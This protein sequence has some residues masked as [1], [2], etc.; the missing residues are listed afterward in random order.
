M[1]N[2]SKR[3]SKEKR[4][5]SLTKMIRHLVLFV[6]LTIFGVSTFLNW[7]FMNA[8]GL[9]LYTMNADTL[10]AS[11]SALMSTT[12]GLEAYKEA[13]METYRSVPEEIRSDPGSDAYKAYFAG[14]THSNFYNQFLNR[15]ESLSRNTRMQDLFLA[16]PDRETSSMVYLADYYEND[17]YPQQ[18]PGYYVDLND[19]ELAA[20]NEEN[21]KEVFF[22]RNRA[23]SL[24]YN[25]QCLAINADSGQTICYAVVA[26]PHIIVTISSTLFFVIYVI[27]CV[28]VFFFVMIFARRRMK[29]RLITPVSDISAAA[30]RYVQEKKG[31]AGKP[32]DCFSKLDI[33]T[34]DELEELSSI[35]TEMEQDIAVYE[36]DLARAA[37]EKGQIHAEMSLATSIQTKMLPDPHTVFPDR[38]DFSIA[39]TM[40]PAKEVGGD[41]YDCFLIDGDHL[42]LV[43]AD[44]SGKGFPAALLMMAAKI[45]ISNFA[46]LGFPPEEVLAKSNAWLCN[47]NATDMF[48]TAWFGILD[49]ATGVVTAANAGHEFPVI[50]SAEGH[51]ELLHDAHGLVLGAMEG[52]TYRP[53][54]LKMEPGSTLYLY[55]DG[56][57]EA[58][59]AENALYGTG[60]LEQVL[61]RAGTADPETLC[62]RVRED[63]DA[64]V[65]DAPQF[66]DMTML[67]VR[68]HG[69]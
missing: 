8:E 25:V 15:L 53:Y 61:N 57:P 14:F 3:G 13:L 50:G 54:T 21:G 2:R 30:E 63:I 64:F 65:M 49:L 6:A 34:G 1:F 22:E 32:T 56:V 52:R 47:S 12:D 28:L 20:F 37:E 44:V 16:V 39:A 45:V 46:A 24:T 60:R 58:T 33:H 10:V 26:M 17:L 9:T 23:G 19:S 36:E 40:C 7:K 67:C 42:G 31:N 66:D 55:T 4:K 48:V 38:R 43:I 62:A 27:L 29:K 18:L 35:L 5:R 51:Y 11:M 68:Y 69:R 41:F 59:N